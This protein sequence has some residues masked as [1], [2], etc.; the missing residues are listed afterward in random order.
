MTETGIKPEIK[1]ET[2][3]TPAAEETQEFYWYGVMVKEYYVRRSIG[4]VLGEV[5]TVLL[6]FDAEIKCEGVYRHKAFIDVESAKR[7]V[8]ATVREIESKT[9]TCEK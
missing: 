7:W 9:D 3:T 4:E 5:R 6:P 2:K 8:E 1:T